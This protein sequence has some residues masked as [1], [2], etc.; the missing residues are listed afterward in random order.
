PA[1]GRLA[2]LAGPDRLGAPAHDPPPR[3]QGRGR[4]RDRAGRAE[5]LAAPEPPPALVLGPGRAAGHVHPRHRLRRGGRGVGGPRRLTDAT[6]NGAG[7]RRG[8][9]S[10]AIHLLPSSLWAAVRML[11]ALAPRGLDGCWDLPG[12]R[13]L[14]TTATL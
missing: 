14:W 6:S 11:C 3:R 12:P 4:R 10:A 13:C 9:L 1:A 2:A 7:P 8:T 5:G